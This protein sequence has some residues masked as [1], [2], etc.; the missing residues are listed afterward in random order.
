MKNFYII[1]NSSKEEAK[2]TVEVVES[3]LRSHGASCQIEQQNRKDGYL[4]GAGCYE[5]R[6]Q[7][8]FLTEK[9]PWWESTAAIW[10]I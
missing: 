8:D 4:R 6:R 5:S 3:Y 7:E 9:S 2:K 1:A 10:V